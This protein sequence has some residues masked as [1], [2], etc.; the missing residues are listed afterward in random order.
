M[1]ERYEASV[2]VPS[3][4]QSG[5]ARAQRCT[6]EVARSTQQGEMSDTHGTG[7]DASAGDV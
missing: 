2:P 1:T 3:Q 6:A 7:T 4:S 5:T